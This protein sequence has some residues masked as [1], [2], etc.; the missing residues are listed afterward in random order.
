MAPTFFTTNIFFLRSY[1][2]N[3]ISKDLA[4]SKNN[5][6]IEKI[7]VPWKNAPLVNLSKL[8]TWQYETNLNKP[9][10]CGIPWSLRRANLQTLIVYV[11]I[12]HFRLSFSFCDRWKCDT[13]LTWTTWM[14]IDQRNN[15]K[16]LIQLNYNKLICNKKKI[17]E[18]KCR[19]VF[20]F[21]QYFAVAR[22]M[23][24]VSWFT[25]YWHKSGQLF[26]S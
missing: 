5:F 12:N 9:S 11:T 14:I 21:I 20:I 8:Y 3:G 13:S 15:L 1:S 23:K 26:Y 22:W 25:C 18:E 4:P 7:C 6:K 19:T 24:Y 10:V 17:V 2:G 16:S